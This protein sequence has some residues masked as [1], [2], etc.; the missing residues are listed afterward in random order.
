MA[1]AR[2]IAGLGSGVSFREAAAL[3]IETR[4]AE[5]FEYAEGVLDTGDI[6]R[7]H[8]MRVATRRLRAAMEFFASC[9]PRK[10]FKRALREVKDLADTLGRR[11]DPDV[12]IA[13]LERIADAL[14]SADA[15]GIASLAGELRT[16]QAAGNDALADALREIEETDLQG[17]LLALAAV[18]RGGE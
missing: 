11:R 13:A 4:A 12:H 18:A 1:K 16:E 6:E 3:A 5:V 14:T 17:R 8:D 15:R 7:V 10:P 9:F 2:D